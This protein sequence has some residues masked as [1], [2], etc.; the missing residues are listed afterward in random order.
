VL[1]KGVRKNHHKDKEKRTL[2]V[3]SGARSARKYCITKKKGKEIGGESRK[4]FQLAAKEKCVS[5][6]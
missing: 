4:P 1:G 5:R 6:E 2:R 3:T